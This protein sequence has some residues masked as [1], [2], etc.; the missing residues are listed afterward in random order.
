[1][2]CIKSCVALL[3]YHLIVLYN[4][5]NRKS[6]AVISSLLED[7]KKPRPIIMA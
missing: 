3:R 6:S 2:V 1:M 7:G 5:D 4:I